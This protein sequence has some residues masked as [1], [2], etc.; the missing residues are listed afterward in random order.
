MNFPNKVW[1]LEIS[2][3]TYVL[4]MKLIIFELRFYGVVNGS[5][6]GVLPVT[7]VVFI[8]VNRLGIIRYNT[9]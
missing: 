4:K 3:M 9:M 6:W 8:L 5:C 1:P 2:F 7:F